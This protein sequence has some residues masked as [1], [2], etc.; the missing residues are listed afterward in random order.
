MGG[1]LGKRYNPRKYLAARR[2]DT[3]RKKQAL[4]DAS[5]VAR[6]LHEN[7]GAEVYG[8]GS[9]FERSRSFS[10]RSDIDLVVKGLPKDRFFSIL[11]EVGE[12]TRFQIDIVPY[13]DANE[14]VRETVQE[15][16]VLL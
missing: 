5:A 7:Y 16:G 4:K 2:N 12:L 15:R 10:K 6:F 13:E 1:A 14:L 8:I 11:A 3:A 9:L